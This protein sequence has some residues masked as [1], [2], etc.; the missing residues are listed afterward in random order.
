[1]ANHDSLTRR[2]AATLMAYAALGALG[3]ARAQ[4]AG[5]TPVKVYKESTCG[6]CGIWAR[7]MSAAGF[8]VEMVDVPD[9]DRIK[10][11]LGVPSRLATCHTAEVGGYLVEGHVPATVVKRL[12]AEKPAGRGVAVPGM[13]VGSPGM[14]G[15]APE[16]Y[17]VFLFGAPSGVSVFARCRGDQEV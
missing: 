12:L 1:M 9:V 17:A 11:Q 2:S 8:S 16:L 7:H 4:S 5:G 6:C 3:E 13:P 10:T 14:E 15:G